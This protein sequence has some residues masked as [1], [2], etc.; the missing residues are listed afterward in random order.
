METT[1]ACKEFIWLKIM[2]LDIGIKQGA[3]TI[4]CDS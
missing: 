3:V 1:H 4:Y 2:C